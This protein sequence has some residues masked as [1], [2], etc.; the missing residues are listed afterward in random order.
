MR[1]MLFDRMHKRGYTCRLKVTLAQALI[2]WRKDEG[3]TSDACDA[4]FG[5]RTGDWLQQ[6]CYIHAHRIAA[7]SDAQAN[8]NPC[9]YAHALRCGSCGVYC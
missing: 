5:D 9:S 1:I 2:V 3:K 7:Y 8:G 4:A 6:P